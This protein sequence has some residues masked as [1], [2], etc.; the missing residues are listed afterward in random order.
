MVWLRENPVLTQLKRGLVGNARIEG[1]VNDLHMSSTYA[2]P[3]LP[4]LF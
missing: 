1:M 3:Q 4:R 2:D